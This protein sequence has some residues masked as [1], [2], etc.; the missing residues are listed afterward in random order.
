M[1]RLAPTHSL[2]TLLPVARYIYVMV[3]VAQKMTK[4]RKLSWF[5]RRQNDLKVKTHI[6]L[7]QFF[8][9]PD[10]NYGRF[11]C[12]AQSGVQHLNY[13][14]YLYG[15]SG[16]GGFMFRACYPMYSGAANLIRHGLKSWR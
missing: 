2:L 13:V 1:A 3:F 6:K 11:G 8:T 14:P 12:F 16:A 5:L 4:W 10:L 9:H 7:S 15:V